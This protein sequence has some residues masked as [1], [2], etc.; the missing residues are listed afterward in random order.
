RWACSGGWRRPGSFPLARG[1]IEETRVTE[2]H[3]PYQETN[4]LCHRCRT[5]TETQ[6]PRA[7][8]PGPGKFREPELGRSVL[9]SKK[10]PPR[11][12]FREPEFGRLV[13]G[14][15][16]DSSRVQEAASAG[17]AAL[18]QGGSGT[19]PGAGTRPPRAPCSLR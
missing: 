18:S 17:S 5:R 13:F 2:P 1:Q 9:G 12:Q 19:V 8:S 4:C 7:P 15:C 14:V 6:F 16:S 11:A 3:P 10:Q